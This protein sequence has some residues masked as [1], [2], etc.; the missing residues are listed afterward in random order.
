[1]DVAPLNYCCTLID[2]GFLPGQLL[3]SRRLKTQ[4]P[5]LP[6]HLKPASTNH[7]EILNKERE[8]KTKTA[9]VHDSRHRAAIKTILAPRRIVYAWDQNMNGIVQQQVA[10]NS[11]TITND[12]DNTIRW[13]RAALVLLLQNTMKRTIQHITVL[14]STLDQCALA[15]PST[16]LERL[17]LSLTNTSRN[18]TQYIYLAVVLIIFIQQSSRYFK[19]TY[20]LLS[21]I[22][23]WEM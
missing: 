4:L 15:P 1:M 5:T 7:S 2:N 14:L 23:E 11:Y 8:C 21:N 17:C 6:N 20:I 3:R 16:I 10:P 22:S 13:N 9:V 18:Y 12:L 19:H